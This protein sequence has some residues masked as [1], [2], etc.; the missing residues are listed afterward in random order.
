MC[1]VLQVSRS[2]YYDFL[3]RSPQPSLGRESLLKSVREI[4]ESSYQSYGSRRISESLKQQGLSVGRFQARSLMRE[5]GVVVKRRKSFVKTTDSEHDSPICRNILNRDFSPEAPNQAWGTDI[6]YLWT[7]EGWLYLA[8]V[9]DF[10]SR[11]IVGWSMQEHMKSDLVEGA[12][13]MAC[14]RRSVSPGL[15][16]HS[17]R[18]SQYASLRYQTQ[19]EHFEMTSS[20]SRRGNCWDNSPTERFFGSL[21]GEL[22]NSLFP[23]SR[24]E[25][26]REVVKYIEMFYNSKRLHSTLGYLS[27]LEFE[28]QAVVSI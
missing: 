17:D 16:H 14:S 21:K 19:L 9:L 7:K 10:Y 3:K 6:T 18:G 23:H 15:I 22:Y 20:M 1:R 28:E 2:G 25:A 13:A 24:S 11:R 8:V 4:F 26:K 12:L 5:A 27:P